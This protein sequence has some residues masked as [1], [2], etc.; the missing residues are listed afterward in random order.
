MRRSLL[1]NPK[2]E[3]IKKHNT[4]SLEKAIQEN[5]AAIIQLVESNTKLVEFLAGGGA[6]TKP[7]AEGGKSEKFADK[8][9]KFAA[10]SAEQIAQYKEE[11]EKPKAEEKKPEPKAPKAS[12]ITGDDLRKVAGKCIAEGKKA[13]FKAVLTQ[14]ETANIT[15]FVKDENSDMSGMLAA[16][17]EVAGCKLAEIAD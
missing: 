1:N 9:E 8:V 5:T 13:E 16:L 10:K 11:T 2:I 12:K 14:F 15:V 7:K 4:M 3:N 17:E 6:P